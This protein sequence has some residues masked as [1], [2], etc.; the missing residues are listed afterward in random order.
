MKLRH[1]NQL[2]VLCGVPLRCGSFHSF[3]FFG[4]NRPMHIPP[5]P[6]RV[7][8][9]FKHAYHS[10]GADRIHRLLIKPGK[11]LRAIRLASKLNLRLVRYL[12]ISGKEVQDFVDA[13]L[14]AGALQ[15]RALR[16]GA[17]KL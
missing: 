5:E 10:G 15:V 14:E 1:N 4:V 6:I 7:K 12:L 11:Y 3:S 8:Q 2:N 17:Q 16:P 9:I 13:D